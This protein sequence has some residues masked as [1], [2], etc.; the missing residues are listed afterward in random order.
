MI[1]AQTLALALGVIACGAAAPTGETKRT[2][3]PMRMTPGGATDFAPGPSIDP[4]GA[5]LE[6]LESVKAG[7]RTR[8]RLPVVVTFE[9][10]YRLGIGAAFVGTTLSEAPADAVRL[11]LDDTGLG[12]ALLDT[13]RHLCPEEA[14]GCALWLEGYCGALVDD[15]LDDAFDDETDDEEGEDDGFAFSVLKVGD[16]VAPGDE[17]RAYV[18]AP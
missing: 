6:W 9:D 10:A 8:V 11:D 4:P 16:P 5:L 14:A 1:R 2:K 12:I 17:A 13:L 15:S 3:S 18:V 7:P